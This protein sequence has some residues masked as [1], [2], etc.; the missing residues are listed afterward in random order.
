MAS[1]SERDGNVQP[2][3]ALQCF[4]KY[5]KL[6]AKH[7]T[8]VAWSR[9]LLTSRSIPYLS[10]SRRITSLNDTPFDLRELAR[11][12]SLDSSKSET[13][14]YLGYASNLSA[15]TF[16]GKRQIKPLSQINVVVPSLSLTFDLPGIPYSEPCFGNVRYRDLS[17]NSYTKEYRPQPPHYHKDRWQKGLVGV[18][19]EVTKA[20]FAHIIATEGGGASYKD[21]LVDCYALLGD[22]SQP[23]P[24]NPSGASFKA[25][26]LFSPPRVLRN[27]PSYAQPSARY[28]KL[29]S[30]GAA[31]HALPS[32]YQEFL[33]GIRPYTVTSNR[34]RLGQFIFLSIWL[35]IFAFLFGGAK[36]FLR[37]DGTYPK[38]LTKLSSALFVACW[39]SYDD[40]FRDT[41][42][43]G[44][45]TVGIDEENQL[46]LAPS[47]EQQKLLQNGHGGAYGM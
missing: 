32:E 8:R 43:E 36:L 34:Q 2:C 29:I 1:S 25:H 47:N 11:S 13:V 23:V 42:G 3:G 30:D 4:S 44:E 14:L 18:V 5:V 24:E 31:E 35:P 22:S 10:E 45:R 12:T 37:K 16:L 17:G 7:A 9:P 39:H 20:D 21:V 28:L 40:I 38:W 27:D 46:H 41:F 15:E 26:T 33:N 19:Y 6:P